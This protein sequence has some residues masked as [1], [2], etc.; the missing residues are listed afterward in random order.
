MGVQL[1][2][3]RAVCEI[4]E[5]GSERNG[6]R[7]LADDGVSVRLCT[8]IVMSTGGMVP[9]EWPDSKNVTLPTA[10]DVPEGQ[11]LRAW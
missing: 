1:G 9:Q 7:C 8:V 5:D 6:R 4:V 10:T 2:K 3:D 11:L